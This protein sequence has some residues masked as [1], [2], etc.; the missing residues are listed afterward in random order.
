VSRIQI[1]GL[2]HFLQNPGLVSLTRPG[3][4]DELEQKNHLRKKLSEIIATGKIELV[5]E[6]AKLD[7]SCLGYSLAR[8][9][10]IGYANITMPIPEREKQGVKTPDYDRTD[11]TRKAAYKIFEAF[12]FER[13]KAHNSATTLVM[14]GRRHYRALGNLFESGGD[15]V[16]LYDIFDCAW[17]RGVPQEGSNC[18][19]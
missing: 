14:C 7:V 16:R 17:Y 2:N 8:E 3:I 9:F 11:V 15:D 4:A 19:L 6:E 5:A 12:M 1:F 10:A 13:I 18:R